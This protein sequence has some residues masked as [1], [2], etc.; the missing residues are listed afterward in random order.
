MAR[1]LTAPK[2]VVATHNAG[3]AA[4]I[5]DLLAPWGIELVSAADLNLPVPDETEDSFEGNAV[6]KA[7][8]A[9]IATGLP[10]L[11]DDSG[12]EV[13]WLGGA[14]GVH[15]ADWAETPNGR[16]FT[17]A[18]HKVQDLLEKMRA[19]EPRY[20][21]F[22]CCLALVWPDGHAE[23]MLGAAEGALTWPPRGEIGHGYDPVFVPDQAAD[24]PNA[25]KR[26]FAEMTAGEKNVVSHR[27]DAFGKLVADCLP[28]LPGS[29]IDA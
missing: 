10:A 23:V 7:R 4:E 14:P 15:T 6:L 5:R 1:I 26:T 16:D 24:G 25:A 27:A 2:I 29:G 11:A 3:K 9:A 20:A 18:M 22:V 21:R 12:L 8:A 13:A 17:M 28:P 19:P